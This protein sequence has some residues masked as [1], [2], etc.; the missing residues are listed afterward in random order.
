MSF[1]FWGLAGAMVALAVA[2][3]LRPLLKQHA[4]DRALAPRGEH[5]ISVYKDQLAEIARDQQRGVITE[6]E[7]KEAEREVQRRLLAAAEDAERAAQPVAR[8]GWAMPATIAV[9]APSAAVG[10]Y[11]LLGSP[12]MPGMPLAERETEVEQAAHMEQAV[13]ELA[14]RLSNDPSNSESWVML[15]RG[16]MVLERFPDAANAFR[17]A[18]ERGLDTAEVNSALGEALTAANGGMVNPPA[19]RAFERALSQEPREPRARYYLGLALYQVGRLDDAKTAWMA[20]LHESPADAP[21]APLLRQNLIQLGAELGAPA[22]SMDLSTAPAA[23]SG[24]PAPSQEAV[25]AI[26]NM[27]ADERAAMIEGMVAQLAERLEQEPDNLEGWLRLAQSYLVLGREQDA[28]AA[29]RR[30]QPLVE[31]LPAEDERRQ[32][33]SEAIAR[34]ETPQSQ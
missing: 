33:V 34:L 9:L 16:Y 7:A 22:D 23:P 21:W 13:A 17:Q 30:A 5:D 29:L 27:S 4:G 1:L 12:G 15:G 25:E 20:L 11:L 26:Q 14:R 24:P 3:L 8:R 28:L 10:L 6:A 32:F 2:L 31:A 19:R 18:R